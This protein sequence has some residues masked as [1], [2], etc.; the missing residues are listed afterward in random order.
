LTVLVD[1]DDD[2]DDAVM[3]LKCCLK[4]TIKHIIKT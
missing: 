1:S 2:D 3:L 4:C